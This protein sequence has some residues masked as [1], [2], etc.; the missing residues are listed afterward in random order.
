MNGS[1]RAALDLVGVG[2]DIAG[3]RIVGSISLS[4][5]ANIVG[6]VGPNGSG[7]STLLRTVYRMLRPAEGRVLDVWSVGA[8][9]V[10]SDGL[11]KSVAR[12]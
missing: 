8:R 6:V 11:C 3:R 4:A 7:K 1:D 9:K 2:V 5:H 12:Q 10:V